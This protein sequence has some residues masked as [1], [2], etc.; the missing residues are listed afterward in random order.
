MKI[1]LNMWVDC[2][3]IF[4]NNAFFIYNPSCTFN[5]QEYKRGHFFALLSFNY[6]YSLTYP[7][8]CIYHTVFP[9]LSIL[10]A[11]I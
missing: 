1:L 7:M 8:L 5:N 10:N 9:I 3:Y 11:D 2:E 4:L 6:I